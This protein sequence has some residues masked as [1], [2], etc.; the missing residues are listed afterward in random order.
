MISERPRGEI[1]V[2]IRSNRHCR[3]RGDPPVGM[4][5]AALD[6]IALRANGRYVPGRVRPYTGAGNRALFGISAH[7]P[8]SRCLLFFMKKFV[9]L[10]IIVYIAAL[11]FPCAPRA[12]AAGNATVSVELDAVGCAAP[13]PPTAVETDGTLRAS[14]AVL[15]L[16][17]QNGYTAFYG[18]TPQDSFYLA[19]VADGDRT[20]SFNGYRCAA[21]DYPV[22][23]PRKLNVRTRIPEKVSAYLTETADY[24]DPSDYETN[25][26]GYLGEFVY[27]NGSG[28]MFSLNGVFL[29]RDLASVTLAPGDTL[30]V[31]YTLWYGADIGGAEPA[32]QAAFD[33]ATAETETTIAAPET[34]APAPETTTAAPETPSAAPETTAQAP[35]V[36]AT[37]ATT[38]TTTEASAETTIEDMTET[39]T[40][41]NTADTET[42][43]PTPAT[44]P[45]ADDAPAQDETAAGTKQNTY[46]Y[47]VIPAAAAVP[48]TAL[49]V[50]IIKKHK[51]KGD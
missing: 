30:R 2:Q 19:Y 49:A 16:L 38:E 26:T 42:E 21:A 17:A 4:P 10:L 12:A 29:Q 5:A 37:E 1:P 20:G 13:V 9:K 41:E 24:F 28:W 44:V 34:T 8:N 6:M 50:V 46:L 22:E 35:T 7:R 39:A 11:L 36:T 43:T 31:R 14:E 47:W 15:R 27:T 45:T 25:F 48:V 40:E 23:Q 51:Q 33:A 18:G 3:Y 32:L